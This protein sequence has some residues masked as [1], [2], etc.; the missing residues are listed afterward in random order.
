MR[1]IRNIFLIAVTAIYFLSCTSDECVFDS[2]TFL[3][4][5]FNVVDTILVNEG[6]LD[7][8]SIY[9]PVWTDSIHSSNKGASGSMVFSLSPDDDSTTIIITSEHEP[10]K[11]TVI[12]YHEKELVFLSPECGFVFTFT[13]NN[14][15]YT[16]HL[17][18]SVK[19]INNE[20]TI[21][22]EGSFEI[23]Y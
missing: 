4:I 16:K 17:I 9:S 10:K 1:I 3:N 11:D 5:E 6:F 20:L 23:Y 22:E 2:E 14:T 19:L 15:S 21:D 12:F 13:I 18:D 8:L 7:S